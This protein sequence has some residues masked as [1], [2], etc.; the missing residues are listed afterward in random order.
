M[1]PPGP[2]TTRR[3]CS[4]SASRIQRG[5]RPGVATRK[6]ASSS[7]WRSVRD[8]ARSPSARPG[9]RTGTRP[10]GARRPPARAASRRAPPR[11]PSGSSGVIDPRRLELVALGV[12]VVRRGRRR[13]SRPG[14]VPGCACPWLAVLRGHDRPLYVV[15]APMSPSA[16][17][18]LGRGERVLPGVWRL[19]LPLPWP[20]VPHCNA[21]AVAAGDGVVLFDTGMHEPGSLAHLE[22]ALEMV[23]LRAGPDPPAWSARTRTPT[24]TARP[25]PSPSARVARSG[26]TR[27][28]ST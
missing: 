1:V 16:T 21:W 27:T 2:G 3:R 5:A 9:A 17:R 19:R 12:A 26:C 4:R 13:A 23:N 6:R 15:S 8:A 24:T 20:G 22:R 25:P 18:E 10:R 11:T 28:T 7:F 14:R